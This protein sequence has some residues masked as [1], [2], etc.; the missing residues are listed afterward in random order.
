MAIK[1]LDRP[2]TRVDIINRLAHLP[3][4]LRDRNEGGQAENL[5]CLIEEM[6][7]DLNKDL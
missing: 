7:N 3:D 5:D 1:L 2:L 6:K 4:L